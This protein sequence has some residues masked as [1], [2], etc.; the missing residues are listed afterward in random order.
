VGPGSIEAEG[1]IVKRE[2]K[3]P[4]AV[5]VAGNPARKV[6]EVTGKDKDFWEMAKELYVNLARKYLEKGMEPVPPPGAPS[7]PYYTA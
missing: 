3:I 5:V 1:S 2:Q 7:P 4:P 6:R